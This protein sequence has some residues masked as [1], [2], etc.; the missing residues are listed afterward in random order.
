MILINFFVSND[1]IEIFIQI[2]EVY[3]KKEFLALIETASHAF[4][5]G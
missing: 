2:Y 1:E 5:R 4:G 3:S